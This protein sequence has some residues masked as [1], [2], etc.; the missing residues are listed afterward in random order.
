MMV[1]IRLCHVELYTKTSTLLQHKYRYFTGN[2]N[3]DTRQNRFTW[4]EKWLFLTDFCW[5]GGYF[6]VLLKRKLKKKEYL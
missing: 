4:L 3:I 5:R 2:F 1:M 6:F